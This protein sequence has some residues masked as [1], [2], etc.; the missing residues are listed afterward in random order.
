MNTNQIII[1]VPE[2]YKAEITGKN[3]NI[4][5]DKPTVTYK[6]RVVHDGIP[7]EKIYDTEEEVRAAM[8]TGDAFLKVE[9]SPSRASVSTHKGSSFHLP[10]LPIKWHWVAIVVGVLMVAYGLYKF[11]LSDNEATT[12]F[13]LVKMAV[14]TV[15][16]VL[17][18]VL[19]WKGGEQ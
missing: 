18:L 17:V 4:V 6:Y 5:E 15:V 2:G 7:S 13:G 16:G 1:N 9:I 19:G 3:I 8:G 12:T 10:H 11:I 14:V